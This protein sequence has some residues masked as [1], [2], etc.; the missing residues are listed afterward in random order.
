ME[1]PLNARV[2]VVVV[3]KRQSILLRLDYMLKNKITVKITDF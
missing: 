2:K 3:L 1:C